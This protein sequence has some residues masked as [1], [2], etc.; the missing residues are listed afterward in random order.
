MAKRLQDRKHLEYVASLPC[1]ICRAGFYVGSSNIQAHHLLKPWNGTRGMG[2]RAGDDNVIPLCF[3]H[4]AKL[5]TK[6]G[7]EYKFFE[8]YGLPKDY[9][10]KIAKKLWEQS[11]DEY[12]DD[13]PF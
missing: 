10:Q 8:A 6:Y 3:E 9:G 7:N 5:H 12:I 2:L 1:V 4:H 11:S 13:L